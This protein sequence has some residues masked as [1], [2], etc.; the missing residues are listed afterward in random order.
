MGGISIKTRAADLEP[1]KKYA[2]YL[3][4]KELVDGRHPEMLTFEN[5][6]EIVPAW[7]AVSM[8]AGIGRLCEAAQ[9]GQVMY[10]V[11]TEEECMDDEEKKEVKIWHLPA[12]KSGNTPFMIVIAGGAYHSVCSMVEAFPPAAKLNELGYTVFI[13]NYRVGSRR[14]MPKPLDDL[15]AAYRYICSCKKQFCLETEEYVVCGFSAGGNLTSLWGTEKYG[16]AKYH[17]PK[18]KAVFPVYAVISSRLMFE[19]SREEFLKTLAGEGE[20]ADA[21]VLDVPDL[22]TKNYPPAYIV[23]CRDDS[24]VPVENSILLKELLDERHIPARLE[25]GE[26]GG[27]SF[28]DGRGTD[29]DGWI[30]RAVTFLESLQ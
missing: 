27:H 13:L 20:L 5:L 16:Y 1:V 22:M 26:K 23:H 24:V 28:G 3:M 14:V 2:K 4:Y 15:A 21:S 30:G 8:A 18:P 12:K 10:D 25:L 6:Q 9:Q 19:E 11:Y 29:A 17:L 7:N